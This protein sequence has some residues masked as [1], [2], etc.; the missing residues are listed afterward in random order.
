MDNAEGYEEATQ[1][2]NEA[3]DHFQASAPSGARYLRQPLA[4][5]I[6]A[7]IV[8]PELALRSLSHAQSGTIYVS[9]SLAYRGAT[10]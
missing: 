2:R 9:P 4:R 8:S 6:T 10:T 5:G 7:S 1:C 3:F